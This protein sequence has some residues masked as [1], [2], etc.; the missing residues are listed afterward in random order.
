MDEIW[1]W[2][3]SLDPNFALLLA[4]P[5]LVVAVSWL[6]EIIRNKL[7]RNRQQLQHATKR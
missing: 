3:Q 5:F 7:R 4:L 2:L 6:G 1:K